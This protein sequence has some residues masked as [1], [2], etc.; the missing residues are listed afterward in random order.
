MSIYV[1][2]IAADDDAAAGLVA[3]SVAVGLIAADADA[4]AVDAGC[5]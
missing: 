5:M 4:A 3:S 1:F 2:T